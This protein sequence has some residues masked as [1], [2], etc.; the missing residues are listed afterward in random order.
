MSPPYR[1]RY[2]HFALAVEI[3]EE[4]AKGRIPADQVIHHHFRQRPQMGVRDRG[5]VA[6]S[7]YGVLRSRRSLAW[8]MKVNESQWNYLVAGFLLDQGW[9]EREFVIKWLGGGGAA[10]ALDRLKCNLAT[11]PLAVRANLPDALAERLLPVYGEQGLLALM[12]AMNQP[13]PV[14]L[15]VNLLKTDRAT[16]QNMLDELG[17]PTEPTPYAPHGLRRHDRRPL[18]NLPAFKDGLF[19]LQDEA[20]QLIGHLLDPKPGERVLDL[21]AG[22][23]G[24]TLQLGALMQSKGQLWA[25]DISAHRLDKLTPRM[26]RAGLSNVRP[27][28]IAGM[29]DTHLKR[30]KG[31]FDRILIDAPCSGTGTWRRNPDLKWR[32]LDLDALNRTQF[33]LLEGS[34]RLLKPGGRIVYATCSIL[35]EENERIVEQ[36]LVRHPEF[37]LLP[38][39]EILATQ[40]ID[41]PVQ[42]AWLRLDPARHGTDGFF[43]AVLERPV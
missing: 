7:V 15:R 11:A 21:C 34:M 37:S 9:A 16:L 23:G 12:Q 26:R 28:P 22:A 20:S 31:T 29:S 25:T 6:E 1:A 30:A 3:L 32:P 24:K 35:P 5:V 27:L 33:E 14:D 40:G 17:L 39:A 2:H 43:A 8:R 42:G 19:E 10:A 4:I 36:C 18:F 38:A 41:V 13:A